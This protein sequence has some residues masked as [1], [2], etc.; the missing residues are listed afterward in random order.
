MSE[1]KII[2]IIIIIAVIFTALLFIIGKPKTPNISMP[3]DSYIENNKTKVFGLTITESTLADVMR[4]FG[5]NAELS[6][7]KDKDGDKSLEAYFYNTTI[8]GIKANV[9]ITLAMNNTIYQML[10]NNIKKTEVTPITANQKITF[11]DYINNKL[12]TTKIN[13]ISFIP[14][15][16]INDKIILQRF[17]VPDKKHDNYL[18]YKAKGLR[19]IN[20][21]NVQILEF[22]NIT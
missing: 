6:L 20:D 22:Y 15:A 17:G 18:L 21:D 5:N 13:S 1:K 11:N 14:R 3:W 12:L 4:V 8:G 16:T 9:I 2:S 19:I 10:K 7:F